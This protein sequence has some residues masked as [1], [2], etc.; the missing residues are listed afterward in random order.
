MI[1]CLGFDIIDNV[2]GMILAQTEMMSVAEGKRI[3]YSGKDT[4]FRDIFSKK[5][6]LIQMYQALHPED[7]SITKADLKIVTLQ[8]ILMNG[9]YNDLG[10]MV[11]KD[12]LMILVEAQSTWS[13]NIVIRSLLYLMNTYQ[14]YFTKYKVQL[15]GSA[16]A[17]L[18]KPELYVIYMGSKGNHPEVL[19][20]K[21]E[22][23][24][25]TDLCIDARVKVIYRS[26]S[27]DIINQYIG[28]CKVF[29]EQVA[30]HGRTLTAAKEI[31]RI[32]RDRNLL[33]EYLR[34][35]EMEVE[36]IMLA[37]FDQEKAWD[38]ERHNMRKEYIQEGITRGIT[39]G[40]TQGINKIALK[41][42]KNN[43]PYDEIASLTDLTYEQIDR[44]AASARGV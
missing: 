13:P 40:I 15:Y 36:G 17:K 32:C 26:D 2:E 12:K 41:M 34:E 14:N 35:R 4:V 38:I 18:P 3:K 42:L 6:Y 44:L 16:K 33:R 10:F 22:F 1:F 20:L 25:D 7:K 27:D 24:P 29:N 19:S 11:R 5:K 23:F 37:L 31:I 30:I 8:S 21:D 9:V 39:Q 43:K 28:F